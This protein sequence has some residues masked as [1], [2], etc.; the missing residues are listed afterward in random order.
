[1]KPRSGS[2]VLLAKAVED[3]EVLDAALAGAKIS[4]EVF[5][6]HAQQAVEKLLKARLTSLA[7]DYPK[8]HNLL[9][10]VELLA[11][12]GESLP[13]DLAGLFRLTPFATTFRYEEV[14]ELALP[15]R[16]ELRV[17]IAQLC[18]HVQRRIGTRSESEQGDRR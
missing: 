8:V 1:M 11:A 7:V 17:K 6:F 10:M 5:G 15:D 13:D 12:A 18:E 4:D 3:M 14:E 2:D 9:T 16:A